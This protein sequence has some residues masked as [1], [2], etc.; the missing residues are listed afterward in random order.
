[1][2]TIVTHP[3]SA[4]SKFTDR[5]S[6]HN[7]IKI[8]VAKCAC[9]LDTV[10]DDDFGTDVI[11]FNHCGYRDRSMVVDRGAPKFIDRL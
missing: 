10:A 7:P 8:G 6:N 1:M 4:T 3:T 2:R 11:A 9:R 5:V